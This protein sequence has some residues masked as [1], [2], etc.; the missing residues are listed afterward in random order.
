MVHGI[1]K[2]ARCSDVHLQRSDSTFNERQMPEYTD[3]GRCYLTFQ[4]V[5]DSERADE[6][7]KISCTRILGCTP[8]RVGL[9]F[10]QKQ[11]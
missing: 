5:L 8:S 11:S 1:D 2:V 6:Q 10:R 9:D 4:H 3:A 7:S